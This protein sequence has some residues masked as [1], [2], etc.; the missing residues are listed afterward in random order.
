M[1]VAAAEGGF[2]TLRIPPKESLKT[3]QSTYLSEGDTAL[4]LVGTEKGIA[5]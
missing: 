4:H 2:N 1:A 3:T 5:S